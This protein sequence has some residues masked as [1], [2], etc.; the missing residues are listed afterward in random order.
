MQKKLNIRVAAVQAESDFVIVTDAGKYRGK[1]G[2][3]LVSSMFGFAVM[4]TQELEKEN[5]GTDEWLA[6]EE[7]R[8]KLALRKG[9]L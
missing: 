4:T 5:M 1:A 8:L 2:D 6:Q 3:W 9:R 7:E